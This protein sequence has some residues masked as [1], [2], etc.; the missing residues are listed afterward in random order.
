MNSWCKNVFLYSSYNLWWSLLPK[1]LL[2]KKI[3]LQN[4]NFDPLDEIIQTWCTATLLPVFMTQRAEVEGLWKDWRGVGIISNVRCNSMSCF[5]WCY[6]ICMLN[7][8]CLFISPPMFLSFSFYAP[9]GSGQEKRSKLVQS[10]TKW[11]DRIG[12]QKLHFRETASR[13]SITYMYYVSLKMKSR[14]IWKT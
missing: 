8:L 10:W 12:T 2:R 13:V 4:D 5:W 14:R 11:K 9:T 6:F 7:F 3:I 1:N